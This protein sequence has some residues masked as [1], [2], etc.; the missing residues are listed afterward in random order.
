MR[1]NRTS[2]SEGGEAQTNELSLPL[3]LC[4]PVTFPVYTSPTRDTQCRRTLR[5]P[6]GSL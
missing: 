1:E 6:I 4:H 5:G 3:S 2:G